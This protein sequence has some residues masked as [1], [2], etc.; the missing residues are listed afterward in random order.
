LTLGLPFAVTGGFPVLV[1]IAAGASSI[2]LLVGALAIGSTMAAAARQKR[3]AL[4]E[5][6]DSLRRLLDEQSSPIVPI[7]NSRV[8]PPLVTIARF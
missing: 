5:E 2:A 6:R 3:E 7:V 4:I 1:F 8:A